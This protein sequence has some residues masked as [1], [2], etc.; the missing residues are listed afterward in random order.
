MR[1]SVAVVVAAA[2]A[3]VVVAVELVVSGHEQVDTCECVVDVVSVS[4]YC[5]HVCGPEYDVAVVVV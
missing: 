4:E 1:L 2:A 3:V 5:L